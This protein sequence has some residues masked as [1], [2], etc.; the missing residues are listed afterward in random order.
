MVRACDALERDMSAI[1]K[2]LE[3]D[4]RLNA[5]QFDVITAE[6]DLIKQRLSAIKKAVT[7]LPDA[8]AK[9]VI[10]ELARRD[11]QGR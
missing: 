1:T 5:A 8:V 11:S 10:E 4:A 2:L 9:A 3:Q 7:E 6:L